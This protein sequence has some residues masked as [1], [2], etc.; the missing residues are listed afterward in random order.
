MKRHFL[1]L[2]ARLRESP[3]P[4]Q[5]KFARRIKRIGLIMALCLTESALASAQNPTGAPPSP[6]DRKCAAL[7][8]LNVV[9]V[10][11]SGLEPPLS[12][13]SGLPPSGYGRNG[14]PATSRIK[15]YCVTGY[16]APQSKFRLK[17]PL[18]SDWNQKFFFY[19]WKP[20]MIACASG[21]SG[22]ECLNERQV[23]S[24]PS[25]SVGITPAMDLVIQGLGSEVRSRHARSGPQ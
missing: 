13:N 17:L 18:P 24:R 6:D 25:F 1:E 10:P 7:T 20:E 4:E 15:Q 2:L 16:V 23:A 12:N 3:R 9:E 11:A 5:N 22:P 21:T 14:V 8:A 19:A